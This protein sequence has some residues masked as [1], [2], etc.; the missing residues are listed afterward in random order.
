MKKHQYSWRKEENKRVK[1]K[2]VN[3]KREV[4]KRRKIG[5]K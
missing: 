2:M 4:R 1:E 3:E 5:G